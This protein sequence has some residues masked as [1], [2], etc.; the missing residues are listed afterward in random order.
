MQIYYFNKRICTGGCIYMTRTIDILLILSDTA[1]EIVD[2][3]IENETDRVLKSQ[4]SHMFEEADCD[5]TCDLHSDD[6]IFLFKEVLKDSHAVDNKFSIFLS[7]MKK[8]LKPE[9]YIYIE[10]PTGPTSITNRI[11]WTNIINLIQKE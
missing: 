11:D 8:I 1:E 5:L 7:K 6:H 3:M 10:L 4:I 2:D 9:E